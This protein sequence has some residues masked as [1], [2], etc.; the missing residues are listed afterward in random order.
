MPL[1]KG[2]TIKNDE[3]EG[4]EDLDSLLDGLDAAIKSNSQ[5][6]LGDAIDAMLDDDAVPPH[7]QGGE[8]DAD[9]DEKPIVK[10]SGSKKKAAEEAVVEEKAEDE[11]EQGGNAGDSGVAEDEHSDDSAVAGDSEEAG[12][13]E[14]AEEEVV[15]TGTQPGP[16]VKKLQAIGYK[17]DATLDEE[18][19]ADL[20]IQH[21]AQSA[22]V[23]N[24]NAHLIRL[25]QQ[26]FGNPELLSKLTG[27][28]RGQ[29]QDD[30]NVATRGGEEVV[31][32]SNTTPAALEKL[33]KL[34]TKWKTLAAKPEYDPAWEASGVSFNGRMFTAPA[35]KPELSDIAHKL[36]I[37]R[38]WQLK[39]LE[40]SADLPDLIDSVREALSGQNTTGG[41]T[42]EKLREII[43]QDH[44]TMAHK[45]VARKIAEENAGWIFLHAGGK[46]VLDP[47]GKL[48]LTKNGEAYNKYFE[49]LR[50]QGMNP[51]TP[52]G[53]KNMSDIAI[54]LTGIDDA[55]AESKK[56]IAGVDGVIAPG[57]KQLSNDAAG[58]G[59]NA[60]LASDKAARLKAREKEKATGKSGG[61]AGIAAKTGGSQDTHSTNRPVNPVKSLEAEFA[62][63][64]RDGGI[65]DS[66]VRFGEGDGDED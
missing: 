13:E 60:S 1:P 62:A 7:A 35:N 59:G 30:G 17:V 61:K 38:D 28:T 64:L 58:K 19:A 42:E 47:A 45:A 51:N 33:A 25:G 23:A 14:S 4:D 66:N 16:L 12:G 20:L 54:S 63:A 53:L 48:I 31:S 50:A 18:T 43:Q 10:K 27:V 49:M 3:D 41:L 46:A 9:A 44:S 55:K 21:H 56:N 5:R 40:I 34:G 39:Q 32:K 36:N 65:T 26:V 8:D 52:E 2:R 22:E 6:K 37:H 24:N 57:K 15:A 29:H 11:L